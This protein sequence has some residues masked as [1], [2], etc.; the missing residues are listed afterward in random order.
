MTNTQRDQLAATLAELGSRNPPAVRAALHMLAGCVLERTESAF[1][2]HCCEFSPLALKST[3]AIERK[4][5]KPEA[6]N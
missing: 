3:D 5:E 4:P 1:A 6:L 2:K